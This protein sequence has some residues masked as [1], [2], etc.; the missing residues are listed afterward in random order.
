MIHI[1]VPPSSEV[2]TFKKVIY[3]RVNDADV[4]V[5]GT[6]QIAAF[7]RNIGYSDQ[8]GSGVRNLYKYTKFY[9]G[10]EPELKEGDVFRIIVPLDEEYSFDYA[11]TVSA[12]DWNISGR[13]PLLN[14]RIEEKGNPESNGFE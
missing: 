4:K 2:H 11:A 13:N 10:K 5:T 7:F 9:S 12:K 3:D 8:L 6:A 14:Q 1:H